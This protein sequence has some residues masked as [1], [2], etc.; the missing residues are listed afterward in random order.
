MKK[1]L[2]VAPHLSTGGLPQYLCKKIELLK[3]SFDI[4][5][6][7]WVD[8]TGGVLVV[9]RNKIVNLVNSDK[10]FTLGEDKTK[11][12]DIINKI[13]P[14]IIHLEE[15]P[16]FFM[17]NNIADAI[18]DPKRYYKIIETSHDSSYDTTQKRYFPDK[19]IFVSEWQIQQ[20]KDIDVPKVV[21]YYPIEYVER[22]NREE[23]LQALGLDPNKKHIL[24]VGL[25]T[26]RKNQAE[27]FEYAKAFPEYEFHCLGNQADN[28][29]HYWEPLMENK[30]SNLTWWNERTDV[31]KFYQAMDLFLFTSRGTNNDKE[32]M[33]LV[34]REAVSYQIPILI[35]NLP[36]YLN[37]WNQFSSIKYLDF[38]SF[39]KNCTLIK[40][41]L[42]N[43]ETINP[44]EEV[45]VVSTYPNLQSVTDTTLECINSL[46]QTGRKI[47]L[48]SHLPVSKELQDLVDYFIYDKENILTKHTFYNYTWFDYG[49]WK[50]DLYLQGEDN[51]LYH[52]PTVY[53]N[54]YNGAALAHS[55]GYK[56]LYFL[57]YDYILNNPSYINDISFILNKKEA[58]VGVK[59]VSEGN[60][61]ITYFLAS[62]PEFYL[63]NF[64]AIKT[65]KEYDDVMVKV[66]SESNGLEN[67]TY[68]AFKRFEDQVYWD[69][70]F[71]QL[72]DNSFTHK[73]YS[74]AEYFSILSINDHPGQFAIFLNV[75]NSRDSRKVVISVF[76]EENQIVEESF[77][78]TTRLSWFKQIII[79]YGKTYYVK[80]SAYDLYNN[81]LIETKEIKVDKEYLESQIYKNGFLTLKKPL[82]IKI[83]HLLT[84][85]DVEREQRSIE[86]LKPLGN[87]LD[88]EYTQI[89][90]TPYTDLPPKD[91]CARPDDV[92]PEPG[93][94]KLS[95]GHYGCWLAHSEAILNCPK[96]DNTVYLFFECDAILQLPTNEFVSKL[97]EAI[98]IAKKHNYTFFS[99]AHN[100]E[101]FNDYGTH[102]DA[103]MFTDAHAYFIMGDKI[104]QVHNQI[105]NSKWDVWDL[106]MTN[107]FTNQPKGFFKEP[108][109]LQAKGY[110]LLDK[111]VSETNIKGD[112]KI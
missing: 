35:Y 69:S 80:Y 18:Y 95:P 46:K 85:P 9:T 100:Y 76:E 73:D 30:P 4:Y 88:I 45:F 72:T 44:E 53:T 55:L 8:C 96:E 28:F 27:F 3:D 1:L 16:E 84:Q 90:N 6:V 61:I 91:T 97:Y 94:Y 26:P 111:K 109:V 17:D 49:D 82:K 62:T 59:N 43:K 38:D 66:G 83:C 36:V 51:D 77:D 106:W 71:L 15:I 20:Y 47:I 48:V 104:D 67:M 68:H 101:V 108:L 13:K 93:Y 32:T 25:F 14:D 103:G 50:V 29:K 2:Y 107:N 89:I 40:N 24:H 102:I 37:Y 81:N 42:E 75:S 12:V 34:I 19:F 64:P 22:P 112:L 65:A 21:V 110:S 52:G 105:R 33:P 54:Y 87:Y 79:D 7:E 63:K 98:N 23:A 11:I 39:D 57:N 10:F 5:L 86:S 92:S 78:I 41:T 31:D 99:F 70:D 74:R 60:T 58:Y 56:K